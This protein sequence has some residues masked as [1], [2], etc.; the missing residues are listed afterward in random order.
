MT[1]L[2]K[3]YKLSM[4]TF[5][6][7]RAGS[8]KSARIYEL[9]SNSLLNNR[10]TLLIVPEQQAV[11]AETKMADLLEKKA[12]DANCELNLEILNF[13]RLCNRVFRE[14]GGLS[15][16]YISKAGKSLLMWQALSELND[17]L[18]EYGGKIDKSRVDLM[19]AAISEFK[20]YRITPSALE[21]S[22]E[23]LE[24]TDP[25]L[26]AKI[27]DI[28]LIYADYSSLL[29]L[30]ADDSSDDLT[31]AAEKIEQNGFFVGADVYFDS[32]N[33]YTP[34]EFELI[35]LAAKQA[36]N[37][38]ISLTL[39][40]GS[41]FENLNDT[42]NKLKRIVG[43]FKVETL[44]EN[45]RHSSPSLRALEQNLWSNSEP[46]DFDVNDIKLIEC[47]N[48]FAECEAVAIDILKKVRHGAYYRDFAVT[49]RG[50][51][52]FDG[53]ID[54]ILEKYGIPC[55]FSKRTSL[56]E[57]PLVR[58]IFSTYSI[59]NGG[60]ATSDVVTYL[61][62]GLSDLSTDESALL[63][64]YIEKWKIRGRN[65]FM[66]DFK[67][68]PNGWKEE[69]DT[70]LLTSINSAREKFISPLG[71]LTESISNTLTV[72]EHAVLLYNY[73]VTLGI[74]A[75][76]DLRAKTSDNA[77][78]AEL[79]QLWSVIVDSLDELV[80]VVSDLKVDSEIFVKLLSIVFDSVDIGR[81]P[82]SVDAVTV[83]DAS[84][85]RANPKHIY[86]IGAN[87]G[88]FPASLNSSGLFS[89]TE[90][91]KLTDLGISLAGNCEYRA[92]DERFT[93]YRAL[94]SAS[95]TLTVTWSN[96][97]LSGKSMR[98][99]LGAMRIKKLFGKLKIIKYDSLKLED[100]LEGRSKL[101]EYAAEAM[102]TPLGNSILD[103][104]KSDEVLSERLKKLQTPL[105]ES[106]AELSK[107]TA[108]LIA[109]GDLSLTQSRLD[110]YVL[111]KFS[112]FCKYILKLQDEEPIDFDSAD[113]GNF[114]HHILE[115][116]VSNLDL[117]NEDIDE[118]VDNI[119]DEYMLK[120]AGQN[121]NMRLA[122]L[123]LKLRRSSKLLCKNI[124]NEF[125][126]SGFVPSFYELPIKFSSDTKSVDPLEVELEDGTHAY[127]YGI[128]DRVDTYKSGGK[129][130]VR[131]ID[132]KTG[133]KDFSMEDISLGLNLQMLLY[134]FS[135]WKNG[136]NTNSALANLAKD[137]EILPAGVLYFGANVP[138]VTLN[139]EISA[140]EVKKLVSDELSRKGIL[141]DD[142][143][144]LRAME[145]DLNG[146]YIPVKEKKDGT[147]Y[148]TDALKT[149][150]DFGILLRSVEST[151]RKIGSEMKRGKMDA[152]PMKTKKH[153][154]CKYCKMRPICRHKNNV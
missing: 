141:L 48:Q 56:S 63:I 79:A 41:P 77:E 126:Q 1:D 103:Y 69:T 20:A 42:A 46:F 102:G 82:A 22:L 129:L 60:F 9:A 150:E 38:T 107:E 109:G 49:M 120:I 52:R 19:L 71:I 87:E 74:P 29:A 33:G 119:V 26:F 127:I 24:N 140:E 118:P 28:S 104:L 108:E 91:E 89:D 123:F 5:I 35:R 10:H 16:N 12:P 115:M 136:K 90:R 3:S 25:A 62:T 73:L 152:V 54:L 34:Q 81:I 8:G 149:L 144:V 78:A 85:L 80:S 70:N 27:S 137:D 98:P 101:I 93:F 15:Y 133:S 6:F 130:Y 97:D 83:G 13:K 53:I 67:L 61:K 113:I 58:L 39:G 36:D 116:F 112:Y 154:A 95:E 135:L 147:Y 40:E 131:V 45:R 76:L 65:F 146:L 64:R 153:D 31:K 99:S 75:K 105:S 7:G 117:T 55:F 96:S 37:L 30:K 145:K 32:F 84:L 51:E 23:N 66:H 47:Q 57:K 148:K 124:A 18:S 68:N 43:E 11:N 100:R 110:S 114:I 132:Y 128:A 14:Y 17:E 139:S 72:R 106:T 138:T 59:L 142:N 44:N 88:V 86:V 2:F 4:T 92:T 143:D 121:E 122:H 151:V 21:H 125:S 94:T 50:F 111:C 134:L